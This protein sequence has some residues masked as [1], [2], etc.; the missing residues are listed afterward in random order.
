MVRKP[1]SKPPPNAEDED[2]NE[3]RD[4]RGHRERQ[5]YESGEKT[6]SRKLELGDRP[7]SADPEHK[8]GG[9]GYSRGE[10]GKLH[11]RQGVGIHD[12][13]SKNRDPLSK[14]LGEDGRQRKYQEK[15]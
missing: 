15:G 12:R 3:A 11:G 10:Q 4:D 14:G 6:F 7:R 13:R 8:I 1:R 9:Y 5:I 2:V